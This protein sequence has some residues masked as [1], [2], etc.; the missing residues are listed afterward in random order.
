MSTPRPENLFSLLDKVTH[1]HPEERAALVLLAVMYAPVSR[2][3][4]A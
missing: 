2:T 1:L 4:F 3:A